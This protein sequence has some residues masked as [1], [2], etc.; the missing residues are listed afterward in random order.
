MKMMY[1]DESLSNATH[2]KEMLMKRLK[3]LKEKEKKRWEDQ[4][5]LVR[6]LKMAE[7]YYKR[8]QSKLLIDCLESV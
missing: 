4:Q 1:R 8:H 7:F 3:Q 2:Q 5:S 6:R